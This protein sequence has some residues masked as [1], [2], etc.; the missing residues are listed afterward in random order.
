VPLALDAPLGVPVGDTGTLDAVHPAD[1]LEAFEEPSTDVIEVEDE[2]YSPA[3]DPSVV[4]AM[5]ADP[6]FSRRLRR[7][8]TRL[9]INRMAKVK[10][11]HTLLHL[12]PQSMKNLV[13]GGCLGNS[14]LT[15]ADVENYFELEPQCLACLST[16]PTPANVPYL[17]PSGR[18]P[19][20]WWEMDAMLIRGCW[21]SIFI[22]GTNGLY[23]TVQNG[24]MTAAG[25]RVAAQ[26]FCDFLRRTFPANDG[27]PITLVVD[28]QSTFGEFVNV[29]RVLTILH[30][31]VEGH[32]NRAEAGVK[33][34]G[35]GY[36]ALKSQ[37]PYPMLPTMDPFAVK[38]MRK[39]RGFFPSTL[40]D[41]HAANA[42]VYGTRLDL[43]AA[44]R[45]Q[46][47]AMGRAIVPIAQRRGNK[48]QEEETKDVVIIGFERSNP[49]NLLL[50]APDTQEVISRGKGFEFTPHNPKLVKAMTAL[51]AH[52]T[53]TAAL[54]TRQPLRL[55]AAAGTSV[56]TSAPPVPAPNV[57]PV[58]TVE[59]PPVVELVPIAEPAAIANDFIEPAINIAAATTAPTQKSSSIDTSRMT[60]GQAGKL[61]AAAVV[62][63]SLAVEF[64]NMERTRV[65][66]VAKVIPPGCTKIRG[67]VVMKAKELDGTYDKLK[68]RLVA[69]GN[70]QNPDECGNTKAPTIDRAAWH[71]L[72]AANKRI[73]GKIRCVDI[74]SAF[75]HAPLNMD[76]VVPPPKAIYMV[77]GASTAKLLCEAQPKFRD[78]LQPDGSLIFEIIKSLYGLRQSPRNWFLHLC[79]IL[80]SAGMVQCVSDRCMF[81]WHFDGKE[82]HICFW[83]DDLFFLGNSDRQMDK[84]LSVLTKHFGKLDVKYDNFNFLGYRIKM[85]EDHSIVIDNTAY[86]LHVLDS[87][88]TEEIGAEFS[89]RRGALTPSREDLFT[90]CDDSH[91]ATPA[92]VQDY[93]T[94]IGELLYAT[95]IRIDILKEITFLSSRNHRP[96]DGARRAL[97]QVIAYLKLNPSKPICFGSEDTTLYAYPDAAYGVH[98]DGLS[99]SGLFITLGMNGGPIYVRSKKQKLVAKSSSESELIAASSI[100]DAS[101]FLAKLMVEMGLQKEVKFVLMEDNTSTIFILR[102]GEGV[103][104]KAKHFLTRYQE[105]TNLVNVGVIKIKHCPTEDMIADYLTKGMIGPGVLRQFERAMFHGDA[106]SQNEQGQLA[107]SRVAANRAK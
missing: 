74:P 70:G 81:S 100:V 61:F 19:G 46:F 84:V 23:W 4:R 86:V 97:R 30:S 13:S 79:D 14:D 32:A 37:L 71:L 105:I 48:S 85:L 87:R 96:C 76:K 73:K 10:K 58:P 31:S 16:M 75:L 49:M 1:I 17:I 63:A 12:G 92:E 38:F 41:T 42:S 39:I 62:A 91:V 98:T 6:L 18:K 3:P 27:E 25:Q 72:M 40:R 20:T 53:Q 26:K 28:W 69:D 88:W 33:K 35:V 59:L 99:H 78:F 8:L 102:N 7:P 82:V 44:V 90:C 65:L 95:W 34:F 2:V 36:K 67:H 107:L 57:E 43:A 104:G 29:I 106:T 9:E 94:Q 89:R 24:A 60:V 50:F 22:D 101:K 11:L 47:G 77:L 56:T 52:Q 83:V 5:L 68:A 51:F 93:Q 80:K 54:S 45:L 66:R 15:K 55:Q 64:D 21:Y 103:G